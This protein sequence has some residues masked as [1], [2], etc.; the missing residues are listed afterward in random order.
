MNSFRK[1]ELQ[2]IEELVRENGQLHTVVDAANQTLSKKVQEMGMNVAEV[3]SESKRKSILEPD[4]LVTSTI[5]TEKLLDQM[6][7]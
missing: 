6:E 2:V 3:I 1:K 4:L 5:I 7:P